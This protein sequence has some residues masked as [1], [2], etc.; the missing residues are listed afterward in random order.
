EGG[1]EVADPLAEDRL[2]RDRHSAMELDAP[3]Q[4]ERV[5]GDLLHD[6][7]LEARPPLTP[8][9]ACGLEHEAGADELVD[10]VGEA[11]AA[12][13]AKNPV[14]EALADDRGD[15]DGLLR[16]RGQPVDARRDHPMERR[17]YFQGGRALAQLPFA[18]LVLRDGARI[19]ER[20]DGLLDEERIAARPRDDLV[21][22]L[23]RY[24][25]ERRLDDPRGLLVGERLEDELRE[26]RAHR[27]RVG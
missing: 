11:R 15:L 7:V 23:A 22:E 3:P 18:V 2:V 1:E 26:V 6:G 13:F 21:A 16:D 12:G 9:A 19:D 24:P 8:L 20:S 25:V 10:R 17:R 27:P 14:A 4:G 5:V